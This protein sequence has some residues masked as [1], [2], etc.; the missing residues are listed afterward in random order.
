M[1]LAYLN[2]AQDGL[3]LMAPRKCDIYEKRKTKT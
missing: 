2:L 3:I 1:D